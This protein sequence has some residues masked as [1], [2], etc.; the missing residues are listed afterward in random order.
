MYADKTAAKRLGSG[1]NPAI[2]EFVSILVASGSQKLLEFF[3]FVDEH[4]WGY[5]ALG[6]MNV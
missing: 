2:G 3:E 6:D 5:C 1:R 4:S